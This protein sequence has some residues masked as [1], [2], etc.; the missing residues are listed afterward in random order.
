MGNS[1]VRVR[2][3]LDRHPGDRYAELMIYAS[4]LIS[5]NYK[6]IPVAYTTIDKLTHYGVHG[7]NLKM[8]AI[9][10]C[11]EETVGRYIII[12]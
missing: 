4:E 1:H 12:K 5:D 10:S 11:S 3:K 2:E 9:I 7:T 6:H 8:V